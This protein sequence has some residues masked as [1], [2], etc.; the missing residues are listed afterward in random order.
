MSLVVAYLAQGKMRL[1]EGGAEPRTI[2][3]AFAQSIHDKALR[4]QQRNSWKNDGGG[5]F[6]GAMLWGRGAGS[7]PDPVWITSVGRGREQG[8]FVFSLTSGSLCALLSSDRLGAEERRLW[9]NNKQRLQHVSQH[10]QTGDF[11]FSVTHQ[12]G[13]AN[14]GVM[15]GGDAGVSEVTEGDSMDTAPSWVPGEPRRLVYQSAGVGRNREGHYLALGPYRVEHL[16]LETA[17]I[18][19]LLEDPEIDFVAPRALANGA[20]YYIRRP[21]EGRPRAN[22][23]RILKD[24]VLMPFRFLYGVFQFFNFFTMKYT[25][26]KLTT[27]ADGARN[28]QLNPQE[29][30]IWGNLIQAQKAQAGEEPPDLVPGSW[31]LMRRQRGTDEVI[32]KSVLAYDVA[33]DG[34][35][36]YSN[37]NALFKITPD[38]RRE[39]IL[40]EALIEQVVLLST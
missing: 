7:D 11:A 13:T 40:S 30:M 26:N 33:E 38:G 19:T 23:F 28:R 39:R 15:I 12:N 36:V 21:Y 31:Q 2:D 27:S 25:G 16:N 17:A 32:A 3:S 4:A 34:T 1:K 10:P 9:N 8:Q 14:L 29:M 35:V 37:G 18:D 6:S 22:P 5:F 24:I 20:L